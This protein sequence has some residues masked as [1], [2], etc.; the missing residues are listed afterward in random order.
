MNGQIIHYTRDPYGGILVI[1]YRKHR[2]LTFDSVF[3]QSKIDRRM[4]H[5]PVHEYNRAMLLPLA[6][7]QPEKVTVLG[8][9]GG[10]MVGALLHLLPGCGIHAVELRPDV[11][12]IA[13]DYFQLPDSPDLT[14]TI[15][16]ARQ[17]I[18]DL[19]DASSGLI[20]ADMYDADSMCELQIQSAFV[21]ECRRILGSD[22]WLSI[23]YHRTPDTNGPLF[24]QLRQE[25][26][27]I[28]LFKSKTNNT[29]IFASKAPFHA[30][31]STDPVLK[32]LEKALPIDWQRL[33]A[34]VI[35][36]C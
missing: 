25:F 5:L 36:L 29:V 4:P 27:A 19:P 7:T 1:D 20:L 33:M 26:A 13:R 14:I 24:M 6:F 35:R 28:L 17:V 8:L 15:A 16:D 23:N 34:R 22:G 12:K 32:S 18:R 3:E 31:H 10:V 30:L 2:V 11:L 21:R 9:G